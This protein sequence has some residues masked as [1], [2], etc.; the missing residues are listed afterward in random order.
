M[1]SCH[2]TSQEWLLVV[3]IRMVSITTTSLQHDFLEM[4]E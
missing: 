4:R 3:M 1:L 2:V